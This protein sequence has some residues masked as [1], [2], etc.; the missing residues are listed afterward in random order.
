MPACFSARP[1]ALGDVVDQPD[2]ADHRGRQ[3][4]PAARSRCRARRCPT[5]PGSR[6]PRRPRAM[7]SMAPANWPMIS[8]FSGLPK[9]MLSVSAERPRADRGQ[10]APGLGHRLRAAASRDRRGSSAACSRWS[11]PAPCWPSVDAHHRGVAAAAASPCCPDRG[12]RTAPRS[13]ACDARSG[14]AIS[15]SSAAIGSVGAGTVPAS[16][17]RPAARRRV[18]GRS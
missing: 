17:S 7:P 1:T 12:G 8:G 14:Q 13:S 16:M 4:R 11:A 15:F 6:A 18:H 10:V 9:F 2:A 5:R 3:D